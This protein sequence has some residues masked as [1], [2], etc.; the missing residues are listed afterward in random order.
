MR[1][2]CT[3]YLGHGGGGTK[4]RK[5][6]LR[7]KQKELAEST[8]PCS[9]SLQC[10]KRWGS[11]LRPYLGELP[12]KSIHWEF[13]IHEVWSHAEV[14]VV[15]SDGRNLAFPQLFFPSPRQAGKQK[16]GERGQWGEEVALSYT[17]LTKIYPVQS[18]HLLDLFSSSGEKHGSCLHAFNC[19]IIIHYEDLLFWNFSLCPC[20]DECN[21]WSGNPQST[22]SVDP[23]NEY[24][25]IES[26]LEFNFGHFV[27]SIPHNLKHFQCSHDLP[28]HLFAHTACK[29]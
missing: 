25:N 11:E 28:L 9:C 24:W 15:Q 14:G 23:S 26:N 7:R 22:H 1:I 16:E 20:S 12:N 2:K 29:Y 17:N 6:Q 8:F 27:V 19:N 4:I 5:S 3:S 13:E 21:V 18:S 10:S